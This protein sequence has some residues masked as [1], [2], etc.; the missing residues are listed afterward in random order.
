MHQYDII[1]HVSASTVRRGDRLTI[2]TT[3]LTVVDMIAISPHD[4]RKRINFA[5]GTTYDF[6]PH[7]TLRALRKT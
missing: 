6:L 7:E 5:D 4:G 3:A 2:G 1:V